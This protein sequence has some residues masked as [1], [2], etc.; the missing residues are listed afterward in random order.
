MADLKV[1]LYRRSLDLRSGAGQ[2]LYAQLVGLDAAGVT[3]AVACERGG[4]KF[5]W[6]TKRW[7]RRYSAAAMPRLQQDGWLVVDHG[8]SIPTAEVVY[9]H[10]LESEARRYVPRA[11]LSAH[12]DRE[13]AF[14][15]RL[16]DATL[17]VANSQLVKGALVRDF[18]LAEARVAVLY[19]GFDP[20]RFNASI[21]R[22]ARAPARRILGVDGA[23]PLIGFVTSG[24]FAKRGLDLFLEAASRIAAV[25]SDAR[26]LVVGSKQLPRSAAEHAL[27]R[28]GRL[29][30]RPK[31]HRPEFWFAALDLFLYTARYEEFGMVVAEAQA[32]GLPVLTSRRVGASECL[33]HNYRPWLLEQPDA[34][35][36]AQHALK[37]LEDSNVRGELAAAATV[38]VAAHDRNAYVRGTIAQL[39]AA[40]KRRLR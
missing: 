32:M 1:L 13:H 29:H 5:W 18:G 38:S 12:S 34:E 21:A 10:N 28:D 36:F 4:L 27:T 3:A 6:R 33:P 15:G 20:E 9:V 40:Q 37:L 30:Y 8:A 17:V 23:T 39:L 19:P 14:F 11:D 2:L 25:R 31:N 24:D 26:F 16:D 7:P 35:L 22:E